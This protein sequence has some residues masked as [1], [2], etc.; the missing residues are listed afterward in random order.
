[1]TISK[2]KVREIANKYKLFIF[3]E[4]DAEKAFRFVWEIIC[5]EHDALEESEPYAT[6]T[7]Q[8]L[9]RAEH[10]VYDLMDEVVEAL[11]GDEDDT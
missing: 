11:G 1:M 2:E 4:G 7:I 8:N 6:V 5:A 3:D 10:E 9:E